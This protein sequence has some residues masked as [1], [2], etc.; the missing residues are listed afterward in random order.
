M[1][2]LNDTKMVIAEIS[3]D[4]ETWNPSSFVLNFIVTNIVRPNV[5]RGV[6]Q[7]QF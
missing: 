3:A 5:E 7:S 6:I 1:L 2:R 4:N